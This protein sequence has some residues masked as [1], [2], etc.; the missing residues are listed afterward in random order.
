MH[1]AN[2]SHFKLGPV[3]N[4]LTQNT[5]MPNHLIQFN[6]KAQNI[7]LVKS[8]GKNNHFIDL[9]LLSAIAAPPV[10]PVPEVT[11][12]PAQDNAAAVDQVVHSQGLGKDHSQEL[13]VLLVHNQVRILDRH[14]QSLDLQ[15]LQLVQLD[16][17]R[18]QT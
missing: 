3:L 15:I 1:T 16:Q 9:R 5:A 7:H 10:E 18:N 13:E 17:I 14:T 11:A 4:F 12:G 6:Y 8:Q 2:S